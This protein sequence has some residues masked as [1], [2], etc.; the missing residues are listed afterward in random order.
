M[1]F[2]FYKYIYLISTI[3]TVYL[4]YHTKIKLFENQAATN[5]VLKPDHRIQHLTVQSISQLLSFCRECACRTHRIYS[6][7]LKQQTPHRINGHYEHIF[8][9]ILHQN[10][11][12]ETLF[13]YFLFTFYAEWTIS[14][15]PRFYQNCSVMLWYSLKVVT[16]LG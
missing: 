14:N 16:R 13:R 12:I 3:K 7:S 8:L 6:Y 9:Y 4:V 2:E 5:I 15:N 1:I 11:C 10:K